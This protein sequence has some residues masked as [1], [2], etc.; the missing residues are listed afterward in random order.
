[1]K[2]NCKRKADALSELARAFEPRPLVKAAG[3]LNEML[4]AT[5]RL[6][7]RTFVTSPVINQKCQ[8]IGVAV[9]ID[10]HGQ[11]LNLLSQ[12]TTLIK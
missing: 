3:G 4:Y 1:M 8:V 11:N 7:P 12:L 9:G 5:S 2:I 10:E 6:T